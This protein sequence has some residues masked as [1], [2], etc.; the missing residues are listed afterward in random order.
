M[1]EKGH[2]I[3]YSAAGSIGKRYARADEVGIPHAITIDYQSLE[4][5]TVTVRSSKDTKQVRRKTS[6]L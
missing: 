5:D 6:E 4:D 1:K 3:F 2:S